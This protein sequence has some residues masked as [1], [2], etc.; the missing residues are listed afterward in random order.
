M[1]SP[2]SS[3]PS[4]II[5][6]DSSSPKGSSLNASFLN[7]NGSNSN[8]SSVPQQNLVYS[9]AL[10]QKTNSS[11]YSNSRETSSI[12]GTGI[13]SERS[14]SSTSEIR[15][16]TKP[17]ILKHSDFNHIN[18]TPSK[19]TIKT[20]NR[21]DNLNEKNQRSSIGNGRKLSSTPSTKTS[22]N[23]TPVSLN[24][25][26]PTKQMQFPENQFIQ[27]LS[28]LSGLSNPSTHW[29][30]KLTILQKLHQYVQLIVDVGNQALDSELP[31]VSESINNELN[32][33]FNSIEEQ[34]S[35]DSFNTSSNETKISIKSDQKL[36]NTS[37]SCA[38]LIIVL[39]DL[40]QDLR[41]SLVKESCELLENLIHGG[42]IEPT[43]WELVPIR[44]L[45]NLH[46]SPLNA[47]K[48]ASE[49]ALNAVIN[50]FI[51]TNI[52]LHDETSSSFIFP[53]IEFSEKCFRN[54][55]LTSDSDIENKQ[56]SLKYLK[57]TIISYPNR[58]QFQDKTFVE[59]RIH[60]LLKKG[61][62]DKNVNISELSTQLI[63]LYNDRQLNSLEIIEDRSRSN[64]IQ[65]TEKSNSRPK[66]PGSLK[67]K[68]KKPILL[69][70]AND[71]SP[72]VNTI[73]LES[74]LVNYS[75]PLTTP[76]T[77]IEGIKYSSVDLERKFN[78]SPT[79]II[80][81]N[82]NSE[83]IDKFNQNNSI[84]SNSQIIKHRRSSLISKND[85][86]EK[87]YTLQDLENAKQEGIK[88]TSSEVAILVSHNNQLETELSNHKLIEAQMTH[89]LTVLDDQ[90]EQYKK[91]YENLLLSN[92]KNSLIEY[93][94]TDN[95]Q[96]IKLKEYEEKIKNLE[97]LLESERLNHAEETILFN[98]KIETMKTKVISVENEY[99][100]VIKNLE[101]IKLD[102]N[103]KIKD[104]EDIS[105]EK[106]KQENK[107]GELMNLNKILSRDNKDLL[108]RVQ[109][110]EEKLEKI[111][112]NDNENN[113]E[114]EHNLKDS[115]D[116]LDGKKFKNL[117][118][119]VDLMRD[120]IKRKDE[121]NS[122]LM[123]MLHEA[124]KRLEKLEQLK[125]TRSA[126]SN[127]I[128]F[129]N[130]NKEI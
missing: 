19:D 109:L 18:M 100:S 8:S 106:Q 9:P 130:E 96:S 36:T 124:V 41:C 78:N 85:N 128:S 72:L 83:I 20:L 81:N 91:K 50:E 1:I 62:E 89:V 87:K 69:S 32:Q 24:K 55:R 77:S 51:R 90:F 48:N 119:K 126:N 98:D 68:S 33:S 63:D 123:K 88:Q 129:R 115:E 125:R 15:K 30:K 66:P 21:N 58:F 27:F 127:L 38:K 112:K 11:I 40:L 13:L 4:Q 2:S 121:Q 16:N 7:S 64:S 17:V 22:T 67:S 10:N 74:L 73:E 93:N 95:N 75:S 12:S 42:I 56:T 103:N 80:Q 82:D 34:E 57:E 120:E 118:K 108:S 46:S 102:L 116:D 35:I 122:E 65:S 28:L 25:S 92:E 37:N 6:Y 105:K 111:S 61:M 113:I 26:R 101:Q 76:N 107:V 84:D 44:K 47:M 5:K 79:K 71:D 99:N 86:E 70:P 31:E 53:F 94:N 114:S 104:I 97:T 54:P 45:L 3:K 117:E 43:I 23:S 60:S 49:K 110:L 14:I 29:S 52:I 39:S 59:E